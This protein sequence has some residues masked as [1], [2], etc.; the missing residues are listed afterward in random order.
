MNGIVET[1]PNRPVRRNDDVIE[2]LRGSGGRTPPDDD[3]DDDDD[4]A[5]WAGQGGFGP[6]LRL[7]RGR[8]RRRRSAS[9]VV[10]V[11]L[12][13]LAF[14]CRERRAGSMKTVGRLDEESEGLILLADDGSFS[15]LLCDP[16]FGLGKTYRVVP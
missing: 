5:R 8:D 7:A 11:V 10:V 14:G 6:D 3:D 16:E 2:V 4:A 15:R 12:L 1:R 9:F 13:L